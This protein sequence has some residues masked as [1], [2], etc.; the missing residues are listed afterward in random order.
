MGLMQSSNPAQR[1]SHESTRTRVGQQPFDLR[2]RHPMRLMPRFGRRAAPDHRACQ[3]NGAKL[4]RPKPIFR[5]MAKAPVTAQTAR[6]AD[7]PAGFLTNLAMQR[8]Q[9]GFSGIDAPTGQLKLRFWD[10]LKGQQRRPV[11]NQ[12]CIGPRPQ[13]IG[14]PLRRQTKTRYH[15]V[16]Y[17]PRHRMP[18]TRAARASHHRTSL[19]TKYPCDGADRINLPI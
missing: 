8:R 10:L 13:T 4:F 6:R 1:R 3:P 17:L 14:A 7:T 15:A 2:Q 5:H 12:Q 19:L 9:R 18:A 16:P 11:A